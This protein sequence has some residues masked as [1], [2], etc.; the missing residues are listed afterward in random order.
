MSTK[1]KAKKREQGTPHST[2][3]ALRTAGEV[4]GVLYGYKTDAL[5]VSVTESDLVK[6]LRETGRNGV[7]SLDVE[8]K[9]FNVVLS[10]Y[11]RDALKGNFKHV[12]FLAINMTEE[13]EVATSV[14]LVG[15][16]PGEKEGGTVTQ[17]NR[18]ITIRVK[19]SDIPDA[20]EVDV[21]ELAIGESLTVGDIR[22]KVSYEILDEDDFTLVA[23]TAPRSQEEL[24]ELEDA[25]VEGAEPEVIGAD[26]EEK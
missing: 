11:Q 20:V 26:E 1:M 18:E 19:P 10:D 17:P 8:G 9:S 15:E 7:I 13:L 2:L 25:A 16:A 24:D 12:D 6:T 21:S 23:I 3:T 4:P 14:H 5:T 22:S